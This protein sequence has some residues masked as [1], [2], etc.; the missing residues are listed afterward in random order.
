MTPLNPIAETR[1]PVLWSHVESPLGSLMAGATENGICL[2]EFTDR[3]RLEAQLLALKKHFGTTLTPGSHKYIAQLENELVE[4]FAGSRIEFTVPLDFPGSP[5]QKKVWTELRRIPYG[6][7]RSYETLAQQIG[8]PKAVRAVG[9]ANGMNRIAILLPCHRVV[10]KDGGLGGYAGGLW[11][12][13]F[14]LNLERS[15]LGK[16][17]APAS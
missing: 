15:T 9:R 4:Y 8:K 10:N 13:H 11:R 2:L 7:T 5:F 14:L 1:E 12:K 6:E 16:E 17:A 3:E